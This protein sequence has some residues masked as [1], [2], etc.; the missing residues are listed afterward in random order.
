MTNIN[1]AVERVGDFLTKVSDDWDYGSYVYPDITGTSEIKEGLYASDIRTILAGLEAEKSEV[2][3][4]NDDIAKLRKIKDAEIE[5]MKDGIAVLEYATN[6]IPNDKRRGIFIRAYVEG[7][8]W[9][10][11]DFD[12]WKSK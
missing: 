6:H 5:R 9:A 3:A 12:G 2:D 7:E 11:R 8:D 4:L 10:V 1:D